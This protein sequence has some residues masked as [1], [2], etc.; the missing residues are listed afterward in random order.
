[1]RSS[2][3]NAFFVLLLICCWPAH[4]FAATGQD[5]PGFDPRAFHMTLTSA[6]EV[7]EAGQQVEITVQLTDAYGAPVT[8]FEVVRGK[9]LHLTI[10]R[11]GLDKF[12]HT[13]PEPGPLGTMVTGMTFPEGG[14]Y[15]F[16]ADFTPRDGSPVTL[17]AEL[18][19]E[20]GGSF[21]PPLDPYVPGMVQTSEMLADVGIEPGLVTD[22]ISFTL[23]DL[24]EEP[25]TDLENFLGA[26][27]HFI[28][29]SADGRQYVHGEP[30]TGDKPNQ[31][32]FEVRFPGPGIY[33]GWGEFKRA[34]AVLVVPV[35]MQID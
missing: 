1:M 26:R 20:G 24:N 34:G 11:E 22:R 29:L 5:S 32:V 10:V 18:H 2:Y 33:K 6:P 23:M 28:A 19:V 13:F 15:F 9:K 25:V 4:L 21:A 8:A 17:M 30:A 27:G 14:T 12:T 7:V 31:V 35:V 16:H 3:S